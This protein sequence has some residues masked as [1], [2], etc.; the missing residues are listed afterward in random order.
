MLDNV[1]IVGL[2][3]ATFNHKEFCM[4]INRVQIK[5]ETY[6]LLCAVAKKHQVSPSA[7][8]S[9]AIHQYIIGLNK[10]LSNTKDS[11]V[12]KSSHIQPPVDAMAQRAAELQAATGQPVGTTD[13]RLQ[14]ALNNWDAEDPS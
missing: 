5:P 8:A 13:A 12:V 6:T 7:L 14:A 3:V 2:N 4:S 11:D 1:F 10:P 9:I